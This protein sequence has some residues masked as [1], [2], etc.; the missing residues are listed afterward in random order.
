MSFKTCSKCGGSGPFGKSAD[1]SDGL[2]VICKQCRKAYSDR[3]ENKSRAK[4]WRVNNRE[5]IQRRN[6]E[7]RFGLTDETFNQLLNTQNNRCAICSIVFDFN[8]S[9]CTPH[10]D[11]CHVTDRIRGLLCTR[12]NVML[13]MSRDQIQTLLRG[14]LYLLDRRV[15]EISESVE[16][17]NVQLIQKLREIITFV[18]RLERVRQREDDRIGMLMGEKSPEEAEV[19]WRRFTD[20]VLIQEDRFMRTHGIGKEKS[21]R[22]SCKERRDH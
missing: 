7:A 10:V 12:C 4:Q 22:Y 2:D 13:G 20:Y 16:E 3:P 18:V 6:R 1:R 19:F 9:A 11:H 14:V 5:H 8:D 15:E 17:L 21:R